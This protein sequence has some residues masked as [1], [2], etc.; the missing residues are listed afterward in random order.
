[1]S[2]LRMLNPVIAT[3]VAV[4][5]GMAALPA[6][7]VAAG[8]GLSR[9]PEASTTTRLADRRSIVVGDRMYEVGAEDGTYPATGWHIHGEMGGFWTQPIKLLDGIWFNVNGKWLT[10]RQYGNGWGYGR[11]DLGSQDGVAITRT[12]FAPDG[13]RAGLIGLTFAS[14]NARSISLTVDAHSELM[15]SYPWGWTTPNAQTYNLPD[16]GAYDGRDLVF[17][18]TGTP[19]VTG[20]EPHNWAALVGSALQPVDHKLGADFRGPQDPAVI[21]PANGPDPGRCDDTEIGKGTGG[22]LRYVVNVPAG[23]TTVWFA[24]AGSDQGVDAAQSAQAAALADPAGLLAA[25]VAH[26]RELNAR[27]NVSLPGDPLLQAS[28]AW[29][30]QNLGDSVQEARNLQVRLVREGNQYPS[31]AGTVDRARWIGAGWPDYPWLFATD[32]EYTAFAAVAAGQFAAIEDHLRALRDVSL[33]ANGNSGKVVHEVVPDGSVY[34]GANADPGNTDETAKFPSAVA[35][36]WRWTG[37]A[38]FRDE[39]YPFAVKNLQYIYANL[40]A[41]GDGW[42]EGLGNVERAGMGQEKLDNTVYTIRGLRDVADMAASKGDTAVQTWATTRANNLESRFEATWWYGPTANQYADSLADPGD[43]KVFQ[44]HWIGLTPVEAELVRPG[45]PAGPLASS[46]HGGVAVAKREE[47]C[48]SGEFGLYH[49]GTGATTDP[50][51]NPGP[52]CDSAISTVHSERSI[53][54]LGTSIMAVSEAALGRMGPTQLQ[55]YTTANARVQ[56]DPSVWEVP[57]DMPEISPSPDFKANIDRLFTDRSMGLQAWGTYGIL[58][59]VVHFELGVAPDLGRGSVQVVPQVPDGQSSV[60][61]SAI[62][63]GS[64]SIDVAATRTPTVLTTTVMAHMSVS[65]TI[66]TVLPTGKTV[67]GVTLNGAPVAYTI[68]PTDRGQEVRVAAG[69]A[70]AAHLVVN[71]A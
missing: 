60:S 71:V 29:S 9:S 52:T 21:C 37:D 43:V 24:V 57:G 56:L 5:L 35:L 12:D 58:W 34:F 16:S 1:M 54:T 36:V 41:D 48:Y 31:P 63:L 20:A 17:R 30:K 15:K 40:D 42:P 18:E 55:R 38:K 6:A 70:G 66:G 62:Q 2:R 7:A 32:G 65:L 46:D 19:P 50:A 67:T 27:T 13:I 28:V 10:A 33:V 4:P 51:G 53:F 59:P 26:R 25:K 49:T 8:G 23:G 39:M 22:E 47:A 3:M 45:Q 44:R 11:M 14:S 68:V 69:S 61:G 64:G